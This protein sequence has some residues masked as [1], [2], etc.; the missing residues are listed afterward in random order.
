MSKINAFV[1]RYATDGH[2][3]EHISSANAWMLADV[4][5]QIDQR[6]GGGHRFEGRI[7]NRCRRSD[8]SNHRSVVIRIDVV[9]ENY[10]AF[11][12]SDRLCDAFDRLRLAAFAEVWYTLD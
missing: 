5:A 11:D 12:R 8:E 6:G 9:I 7:H 10:R 4:F 1:D 3:R 2:E